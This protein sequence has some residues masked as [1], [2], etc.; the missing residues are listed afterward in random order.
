MTQQQCIYALA[1][2]AQE[3]LAGREV[4]TAFKA[5]NERLKAENEKL[6]AV[7]FALGAENT[8]LLKA[9]DS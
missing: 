4:A 8:A 5:E 6:Q 1:A 7:N 2:Y 9:A 3:A